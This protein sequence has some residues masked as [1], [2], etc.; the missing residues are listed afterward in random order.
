VQNLVLNA[1]KATEQGGVVVRWFP[2]TDKDA[3]QWSVLVQDTG[4]GLQTQAAGPLLTA[5]KDAT[6]DAQSGEAAAHPSS[7]PRNAQTP[8]LLLSQ[9]EKQPNTPP[10]G[11][12]IGLTIVKR[13]CE[14]LGASV[15]L[16]TAKGTGTTIQINFPLHYANG[17]KV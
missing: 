15:E 9:T 4:P 5:L 17:P 12:G 3:Q 8:M 6:K 13:L 1:L 2:R 11:E 14:L 16:N 10:S 7:G